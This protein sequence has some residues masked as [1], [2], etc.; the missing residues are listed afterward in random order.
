MKKIT[1]ILCTF[2]LAGALLLASPL[3]AA[4]SSTPIFRGQET[5]VPLPDDTPENQVS[6]SDLGLPADLFLQGPLGSHTLHFSLPPNDAPGRPAS[7]P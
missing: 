5:P 2:L 1:L 3:Q 4:A 6:F 7:R